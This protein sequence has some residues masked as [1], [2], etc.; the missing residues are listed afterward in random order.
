MNGL[1]EQNNGISMV[2]PRE[3]RRDMKVIR[4]QC[5]CGR[6]FNKNSSDSRCQCDQCDQELRVIVSVKNV[7]K[8]I[9]ESNEFQSNV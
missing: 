9:G 2:N 7:V 3:S 1:M 6:F 8:K 4:V 5:D